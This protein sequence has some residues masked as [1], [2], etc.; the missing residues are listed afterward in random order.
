MKPEDL[1][2][3][4]SLPADLQWIARHHAL[5]PD[6]PVYLLL[7]WH[8][9]RISAA[10][11]TLQAAILEL[12]TA[13]DARIEVMA[14]TADAVAGVNTGLEFLQSELSEQPEKLRQ[15]LATKVNQPVAS[16]IRQLETLNQTLKPLGQLFQHM[17]RRQLIAM[18]LCGAALGSIATTIL[19]E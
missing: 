7:A 5:H 17:Q 12:K 14:E 1:F 2:E 11:D 3:T 19:L 18:F 6:D 16:A 15:E 13:L 4:E 9:Q 10:E 8:W